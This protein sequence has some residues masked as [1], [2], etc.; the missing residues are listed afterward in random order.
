MQKSDTSQVIFLSEM[1]Q[2]FQELWKLRLRSVFEKKNP[3]FNFK[4]SVKNCRYLRALK[5]L[6]KEEL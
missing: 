4:S 5:K 2:D 1:N 3:A 6:I